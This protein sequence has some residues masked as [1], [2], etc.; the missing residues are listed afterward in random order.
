MTASKYTAS[1][2]KKENI[3]PGVKKF[4]FQPETNIDFTAG[5][6]AF[7]EFSDKDKKFSKPFSISNSPHRDNIQMTTIISDSDYKQAL[8]SLKEGTEITIRGPLGNF[9]L[10][11]CRKNR[12]AYLTGGIGLT[13]VKSMVE[14]IDY[15]NS[16]KYEDI[17]LFYSN[18]NVKRIAYKDELDSLSENISG[19]QVV[20]TITDMEDPVNKDWEGETG[21][22]DR[23][24][25]E[26]YLTPREYHYFIVGPPGFN[27][28]MYN[29]LTGD[30][31]IEPDYITRE[32][33][34]GY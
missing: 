23:K 10:K 32:N 18:R 4:V 30:L 19:F 3:C 26:K 14:Y 28:A 33:F 31:K 9:T 13:P 29:M 20:H 22:I 27:D 11:T 25:L 1:L 17:K 34:A 15:T 16:D 8:D 7:F 2:E 6:Y 5:Q 24:M 12:I 21:Y